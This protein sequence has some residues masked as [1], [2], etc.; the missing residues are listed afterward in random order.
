M[1]AAPQAILEKFIEVRIDADLDALTAGARAA[2][3]HLVRAMSAIDPLFM[4]QMG[5]GVPAISERLAGQ[6]TPEARAFRLFKSPWNKLEHDEPFVEG[7]GPA[8]PGRALYPEELSAEGLEGYLASHPEQK[9]SL[10]DP[11]TTVERR[12]DRLEA[13]PYHQAYA[14]GL[15][16][17]AEALRQAAAV[18][19]HRELAAYLSGR[20]LALTGHL[21]LRESDADW[22]KLKRPP[23]EVV[24]GPFEV[25]QDQL[26][27]VKAFYE[28]ML[29]AVV[30]EACERLATIEQGLDELAAAIPCPA[31]SRP[32]VGGM[33]PMIVADELL[34]TGDGASGIHAV[35]FNL[36][37]DPWV[38]GHV[39]WKQVMIRNMM[40]AKFD[41]IARPVAERV[42][43]ADQLSHLSFEAFFHFVLLHEV[44]HGLGPAFRADGAS[45]NAACGVAYSALEEAKADIGGLT[46]LLGMGGRIG[47]PALDPLDIGC[48][49]LAGL[50]R[51]SRFGLAEAHGKANV[52]Q[53][54]FLNE[55]GALR[56]AG[57]RVAIDAALL[58]R[59][60]RRLLDKLTLLQAAG[61]PREISEFLGRY[62][63]P[64]QGLLDAVAGLADLPVDIVP[65][66]P[67]VG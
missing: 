66:W 49:Y 35:A 63:T 36:P 4:A 55:E 23:L 1:S 65:L 14:K 64:P 5:P 56:A 26:R 53:Y 41:H 20:A 13:V 18:V 38:R 19:E 50:Y 6:Q 24:I 40:R 57:G 33:A 59:A 29:L 2:L 10:L 61:S 44:T 43:A 32:A 25:Y 48:S 37:N 16:P 21:A 52:I 60:A 58:P 27:G 17:V 39:G 62:A 54:N 47:I 67:Q 28:G 22:V 11:Y 30:P 31:G 46:L 9:T 42:L 15:E 45:V 8:Q 51:S 34:A 3:P 7:A 12:G